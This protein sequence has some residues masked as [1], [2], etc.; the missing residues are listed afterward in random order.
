MNWRQQYGHRVKQGVST[1]FKSPGHMQGK[2]FPGGSGGGEIC[3]LKGK[4]CTACK[5]KGGSHRSGSQMHTEFALCMQGEECC[6][7]EERFCALQR[8]LNPESYS[9]LFHKVLRVKPELPL[10]HFRFYLETKMLSC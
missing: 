9:L 6:K 7:R 10:F 8:F 3:A 5:K 1:L 4:K 2:N